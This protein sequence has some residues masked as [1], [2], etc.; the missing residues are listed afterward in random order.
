M[1]FAAV[2]VI[3]D[4]R[5]WAL[6]VQILSDILRSQNGAIKQPFR[7][8]EDVA[9]V[10]LLNSVCLCRSIQFDRSQPQRG[11]RLLQSGPSMEIRLP[12]FKIRSRRIQRCIPGC[13][14]RTQA[15]DAVVSMMLTICCE[16]RHRQTVSLRSVW[17]AI[18]RDVRFRNPGSS[19]TDV[20]N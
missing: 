3:H 5:D 9:G 17:Q 11:T 2:F 16:V 6:D 18:S 4:P 13:L 12:A 14:H 7:T 19:E 20:S 10:F 8:N 15:K 1:Q